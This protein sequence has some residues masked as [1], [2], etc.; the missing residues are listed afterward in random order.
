[1]NKRK[2]KF[3]TPK[4][5]D[6]FDYWTV[7]NNEIVDI[8]NRNYGVL[9]KCKCGTE[10]IV[11]ITALCNGKSKGC[12]CRAFDKMRE[13][14][15]YVGDISDTFWSR[16]MKSAKIRNINFE[17]TKEFAWDLFLLQGKKCALTGLDIK[18]EKS[19]SRKK[20]ESNIT[21][22]IDRINSNEG[23][24]ENNIQ[25]VHKDINKMKQDFDENYFLE[26]CELIT[27][28]KKTK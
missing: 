8:K 3:E 21:A 15:N 14:R 6:T 11:R 2:L 19:V 16:I 18:I 24:V 10:S 9:C 5:G 13:I 28:N 1:M 4:I 22:S 7:I 27:K 26:I 12:V 25:W 23:Y 20:G 17:I